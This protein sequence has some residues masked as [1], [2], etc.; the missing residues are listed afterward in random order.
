MDP[1]SVLL[2]DVDV[3]FINVL[4]L[5]TEM[6]DGERNSNSLFGRI[7]YSLKLGAWAQ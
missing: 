5:H 2:T 6:V 7:K 3:D 1:F 4:I